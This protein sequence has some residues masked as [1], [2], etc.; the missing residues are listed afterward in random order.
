MAICRGVRGGGWSWRAGGVTAARGATAAVKVAA[1]AGSGRLEPVI[2][3]ALLA[4]V[5]ASATATSTAP[6]NVRVIGIELRLYVRLRDNG[7]LWPGAQSC[8]RFRP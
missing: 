3:A 7:H 1:G 6:A 8:A 5:L 4:V 2:R